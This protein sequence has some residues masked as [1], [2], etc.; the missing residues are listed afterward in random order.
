M[1]RI[2]SSPAGA[3]PAPLRTCPRSTDPPSRP[4]SPNATL[5]ASVSENRN[6]S[7]G[8]KP[9]APR[10]T[11]SGIS[12]TSTPSTKTVPGGGSCSRAS[13]LMSVDLPEPVTP[14]SATVCPASMRADT[15][16][17]TGGPP[18][19]EHQVA[20]LDRAADLVAGRRGGPAEAGPTSPMPRLLVSCP[21]S[22]GP[23]RCGS[24]RGSPARSRSTSSIRFHDAMPRCSMLVTQP[25][26]IIG[27][28]SSV[29][30][31]LNATN[32]PS[33]M[34]PADRPRGCRATARAA[35]RGR[36]RSAMLGKKK[37]CSA[38][39]LRLRAR[40]SAFDTR[41]RSISAASCR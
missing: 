28:L 26:A 2:R 37:P 3:P 36:G 22:G 39:S 11:A 4:S 21:P 23:R 38:I 32:S 6:G 16:S 34:R 41:N 1:R 12:R 18:K 5:S 33:V 13:R 9:M 14:T 35:R 27:Q 24:R 19:R 10:R 25:N 17:S 8:T 29:R 7:C 15:W 40:Y 31:A 20:E 30:Y